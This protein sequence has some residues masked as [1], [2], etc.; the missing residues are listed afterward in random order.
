MA[1]ANSKLFAPIK[2]GAS[3]LEHRLVM[4]PL[5]RFRATDEH[6]PTDLM[7]QYYAQR[8]IVPGTLIL[9]EASFVSARAGGYANIPGLWSD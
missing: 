7:A 5:T 2:I 3:D 6:V 1:T 4:A 9:S 8:A